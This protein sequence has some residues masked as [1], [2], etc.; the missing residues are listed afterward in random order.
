MRKLFLIAACV[1]TL[2]LASCTGVSYL[3]NTARTE[4]VLSQNNYRVLNQVEGTSESTYILGFGGC[5]EKSLKDNAVN[6]MF[7]KVSLK[8]GQAIANITFTTSVKTV[9]GIYTEMTVT[10]HG[11]L[12]EFTR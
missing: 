4:V 10:A 2:G 6:D 5:S 3:T 1:A 9:L 11:T 8:D 12:I 7:S